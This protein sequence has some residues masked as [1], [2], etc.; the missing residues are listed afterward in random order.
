[1]H[2]V[3]ATATSR[4]I[5]Y[6]QHFVDAWR[7]DVKR[8]SFAEA[9]ASQEEAI[10]H[11]LPAL[12]RERAAFRRLAYAIR[13]GLGHAEANPGPLQDLVRQTGPVHVQVDAN[14]AD[15]PGTFPNGNSTTVP[16]L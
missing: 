1:M 2:I 13:R 6:A 7:R 14:P 16:T 3:D 10:F 12:E 11:D 8:R 15:T 5:T 4:L 9:I